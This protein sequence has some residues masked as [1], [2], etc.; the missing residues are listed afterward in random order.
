[1]R[2]E[3]ALLWPEAMDDPARLHR[4]VG[5]GLA[6]ISPLAAA[7]LVV[8]LA[9][10][11]VPCSSPAH[12]RSLVAPCAAPTASEGDAARSA[13]VLP[14]R[15]EPGARQQVL[16][17]RVASELE[18]GEGAALPAVS[19]ARLLRLLVDLDLDAGRLEG[20]LATLRAADAEADA[21]VHAGWR[22]SK[23]EQPELA[24]QA[25]VEALRR[26]P[27]GYYAFEALCELDPAAAL[28]LLA[29]RPASGAA[30]VERA[31]QRARLLAGCGRTDEAVA[32][33]RDVR[34][35]FGDHERYWDLLA[36]LDAA[37]ARALLAERAASGDD[38]GAVA[39][40]ARA[41]A[42]EGRLDEALALL[43]RP[44]SD[45]DVSAAAL[46]VLA[47]LDPR[48]ADA[49]LLAA[50]EASPHDARLWSRAGDNA[51]ALGRV[52]A[53]LDR[54]QRAL[55]LDGEGWLGDEAARALWTHRREPFLAALGR[56]AERAAPDEA[57]WAWERYG[58][59][60]WRSGRVD[61][62]CAAWSAALGASP[63][64]PDAARKLAHAAAGRWPL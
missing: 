21:W 63:E 1:M 8:G 12:P 41:T 52:D 61:E 44:W 62:A 57:E 6:L 43:E 39:R 7:L 29:R 53:A 64:D 31:M 14:L 51:L 27:G 9:P 18:R 11:G 46:D 35:T 30:P 2:S 25:F 54:W 45:P 59:W 56:H 47:E 19:E 13:L 23:G 16:M 15:S 24:R 10:G 32:A 4:A 33:L 40:L 34:P 22:L 26:E 5:A 50:G 20:A 48:R 55:E 17:R 36:S 58:D 42:G 37:A 49:A 28:E 3:R 38:P 60:L